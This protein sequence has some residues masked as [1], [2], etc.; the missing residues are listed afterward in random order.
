MEFNIMLLREFSNIVLIRN[1][2]LRTLR[3][4]A[5]LIRSPDIIENAAV[6]NEYGILVGKK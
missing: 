4:T 5:L 2:D 3:C 1:Y 6:M